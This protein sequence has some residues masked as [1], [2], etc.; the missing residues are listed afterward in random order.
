VETSERGH[1]RSICKGMTN[2]NI[3]GCNIQINQHEAR[4]RSKLV[5]GKSKI[6][7]MMVKRKLY[8]T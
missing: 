7:A 8:R 3:D 6:T 5:E 4:L 1:E 2:S